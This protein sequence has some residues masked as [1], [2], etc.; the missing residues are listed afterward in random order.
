L[1]EKS[2]AAG[3]EHGT[4][5]PQGQNELASHAKPPHRRIRRPDSVSPVKQECPKQMLIGTPKWQ[6]RGGLVPNKGAVICKQVNQIRP[7]D[8]RAPLAINAR[9]TPV[10]QPDLSGI[11]I[12]KSRGRRD[13][14][15]KGAAEADAQN[16]RPTAFSQVSVTWWLAAL[17]SRPH[18][19]GQN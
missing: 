7:E 10:G 17:R 15:S 6:K 9:Y 5:E 3:I 14:Y 4:R 13:R 11:V 1:G 2:G 16:S 12:R 19:S 18:L 8:L